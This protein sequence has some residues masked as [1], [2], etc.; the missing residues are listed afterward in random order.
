[1]RYGWPGNIRQLKNAVYRA[2]TQLEGYELRPQDILLPDYDAGTV[3]VGEEAME[4][5][6]DDI[7]SRLSVL[8]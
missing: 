5:S 1:M 3:S 6:L 2:L 4:G 7:T 8:C